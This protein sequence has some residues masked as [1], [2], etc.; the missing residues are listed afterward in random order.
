MSQQQP[1]QAQQE[2]YLQTVRAEVQTKMVQELM[3]SMSEKCFSK[4]TGK[5]G[6][7]LDSKEKNCLANCMDRYMETM[8]V[9][10]GVMASKQNS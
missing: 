1:S 10:N 6:E 7:H 3:S 4:C 5:S 2:Q 8:N 9:V